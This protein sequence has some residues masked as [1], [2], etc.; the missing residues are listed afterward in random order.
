VPIED[1]KDSL[2]LVL[3][4]LKE[5]VLCEWPSHGMLLCAKDEKTGKIEPL[6]PAP[7]SKPGD[8]VYFGD[9]P[10][11]PLAELPSKKSPWDSVKDHLIINEDKEATYEKKYLWK[12]SA[13]SVTV[14]SLTNAPIS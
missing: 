3:C 14:K 12:T 2:V 6:R 5:R 1:L 11:A 10:R 8:L 13:G 4:N 7:G 9:F